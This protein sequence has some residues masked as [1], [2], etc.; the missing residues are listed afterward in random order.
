MRWNPL[1]IDAL[2]AGFACADRDN[3]EL[4]CGP[5]R[6][7]AVSVSLTASQLSLIPPP[8]LGTRQ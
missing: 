5:L 3:V 1:A 2:V 8:V 4:A 7:H 6:G